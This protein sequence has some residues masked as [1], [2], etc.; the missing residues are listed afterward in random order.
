MSNSRGVGTPILTKI[1]F[2]VPDELHDNDGNILVLDISPQCT[3]ETIGAV[4]GPNVDGEG[5]FHAV[6]YCS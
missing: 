5:F 6:N 3:C 1:T 4:F 2:T